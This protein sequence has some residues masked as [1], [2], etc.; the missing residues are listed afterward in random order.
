[1]GLALLVPLQGPPG[2]DSPEPAAREPSTAHLTVPA[3]FELEL[4]AAE[5]SVL[6]PV[7]LAIDVNGEVYVAETFRFGAAIMDTPDYLIEDLQNTT[8]A[9]RV[10][11]VERIPQFASY[12][13]SSEQVRW[14]RD[15]DGDGRADADTIFAA[16][17]AGSAT[18]VGSGLLANG[19]DLYY[20]CVPTLWRLND[21]DRNRRADERTVLS[22]GYG[23]NVS[24]SGHGLHGLRIGPDG[25]LY[26]SIGDRGLHVVTESGTLSVPDTGAVLRCKLDGSGLEV[27]ATG[28]RNPQELAFDE[29]GDLFTA[30]NNSD[31]VDA[32][33][34]VHVLEGSDS[35][36]RYGYQWVTEPA[37]RGPWTYES[38]W[39]AAHEGQAAYLLP[40]IGHVSRGPSGLTYDPG[41]GLPA[42]FARH[43][44]LCDYANDPIDSGVHAFALEPHGATYRVS[45]VQPFLRGA[46]AS[47]CDF[48]PDGT[49]FVTDWVEDGDQPDKGRVYRI[50]DAASIAPDTAALLRR[51][52]TECELGELRQRLE[53]ADQRV[54]Q[55]AQFELVDR[56]ARDELVDAAVA[57]AGLARLHGV[58]GLAMLDSPAV[59]AECVLPL[60]TDGDAEVRAQA[61]KVLR[62][63]PPE[64]SA[65]ALI[66]ALR[67]PAPR[68]RAFAALSLAH[69][70]DALAVRPLLDLLARDGDDPALRH[71]AVF[72]LAGCAE[73]AAL[74]ELDEE[75]RPV[76]LGAVVALRRLRAAQVAAY[77]S[78]ADELVVLEAARAIYDLPLEGSLPALGALLERERPLEY[79]LGRRVLHALARERTAAAG[80]ALL[81]F[82]RRA[83]Q[84]ERLRIEALEELAV[85]TSPSS[86]DPVTGA[87]RQVRPDVAPLAHANLALAL[88]ATPELQAVEASPAAI[89]AR[90]MR[91]FRAAPTPAARPLLE[92]VAL[93]GSRRPGA[94]MA[95]LGAVEAL[96]VDPVPLAERLMEDPRP[97]L[98]AAALELLGQRQ[99][100]R[101]LDW[102]RRLARVGTSEERRVAYRQLPELDPDFARELFSSELDA[103]DAGQLPPELAFD[104]VAAARSQGD[105]A[106][107]ARLAARADE[108]LAA[109]PLAA[110]FLDGLFGGTVGN[111]R[112]LYRRPALQCL[113]CHGLPGDAAPARPDLVGSDLRELGARLTPLEMLESIVDPG[114]D[115][116]PEYQTIDFH[117]LD[118]TRTSGRVLGEE[119]GI[120]RVHAA[121]GVLHELQRDDIESERA[122][123][124]AMPNGYGQLISPAE[125]RDLLAY[126]GSL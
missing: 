112:K 55:A 87:W 106:L 110:P 12:F 74:L 120:V 45:S 71:A 3:G 70:G 6:N 125:M 2:G 29:R 98:R 82:A 57:G 18:G 111:G 22:T 47:D 81:T 107:L 10:E 95:A 73:P 101:A 62:G 109:D 102:L 108:R 50:F 126:L 40:P 91:L 5:P 34:I 92:R 44:F 19:E 99:P 93:D 1:M 49:L 94:S 7:C 39:K 88:S 32:S 104:L 100:A 64:A 97:K 54:R 61:A 43:F 75:P 113:R 58:W 16:D 105:P 69:V 21:V 63:G 30:D 56:A 38:L 25:L 123:S 37:L 116:A 13:P 72:G 86:R 42:A 41:T 52:P 27:F 51:A 31:G 24:Y 121:D 33:R 4:F 78:D 76:R 20:G 53:H 90:W 103:L 67:D 9:E 36:W 115:V 60:L 23:V 59:L 83:D 80:A 26:F 122:S 119:D 17:F 14:L 48:G 77:L 114:R 65:P 11:L 89:L 79:L 85:W 118:G 46:L 124:S 96:E 35:G 68:V 28:L 84:D 66:A 117:L 8:V 15:G